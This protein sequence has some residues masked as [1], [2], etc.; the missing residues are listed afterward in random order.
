[1]FT[2][3]EGHTEMVLKAAPTEINVNKKGCFKTAF[4]VS[5]VCS[6]FIL[7]MEFV[8][9]DNSSLERKMCNGDL[10]KRGLKSE[11]R[12][13]NISEGRATSSL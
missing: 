12:N 1:M 2:T 10:V 8:L 5:F 9:R 4:Y 7:Y 6:E 11:S 3:V 13:R